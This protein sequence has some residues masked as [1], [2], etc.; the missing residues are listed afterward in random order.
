M[1]VAEDTPFPA[2]QRRPGQSVADVIAER[3]KA[4]AA[5][6][7]VDLSWASTDQMMRLHQYNVFPNMSLLANADHL[8]VLTSH[9]GTGPRSRRTGDDL[10]DADAAGRAAN[11]A[12]RRAD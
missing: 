8:T 3:T 7:G 2:D 9:P 5:E 1:G 4:F 6:R 10:V 12:G 11:Q